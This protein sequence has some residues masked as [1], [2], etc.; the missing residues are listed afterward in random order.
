MSDFNEEKI[1]DFQ[2]NNFFKSRSAANI[3]KQ[4]TIDT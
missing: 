2:F 3:K 4:S 1:L